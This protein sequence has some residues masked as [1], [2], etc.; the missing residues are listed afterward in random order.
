MSANA[1]EENT[2]RLGLCYGFES[3]GMTVS[4]EIQGIGPIKGR[5]PQVSRCPF[6]DELLVR[7]I[8][9]LHRNGVDVRVGGNDN[10]VIFF[11]KS[12]CAEGNDR[13]N[14]MCV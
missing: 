7:H 10:G 12:M 3:S 2:A 1:V 4:P 6:L 9:D 8:F 11:V 13:S 14:A 5:T